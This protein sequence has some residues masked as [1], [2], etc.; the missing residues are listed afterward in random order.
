[1]LQ[2]ENEQCCITA[3]AIEA[4]EAIEAIEAVEELKPVSLRLEVSALL[5]T[6]QQKP[7]TYQLCW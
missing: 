5:P 2:A 1:M 3:E 6:G 4:V 7:V